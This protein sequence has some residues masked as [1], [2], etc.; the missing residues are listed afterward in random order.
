M[1]YTNR[2]DYA[3][4]RAECRKT[5]T[6]QLIRDHGGPCDARRE[7]RRWLDLLAELDAEAEETGAQT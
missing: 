7:E 3:K 6:C 5:E 2:E 1:S 4:E